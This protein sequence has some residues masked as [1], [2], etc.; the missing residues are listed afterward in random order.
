MRARKLGASCGSPARVD[1]RK[2][3]GESRAGTGDGVKHSRTDL[4]P[5]DLVRGGG[6]FT[7][8]NE[9]ILTVFRHACPGHVF[10]LLRYRK[11]FDIFALRCANLVEIHSH[12]GVR[13]R[14]APSLHIIRLDVVVSQRCRR[15]V[16]RVEKACP[17]ARRRG[18]QRGMQAHELAS[19]Q[20][21]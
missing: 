10:G 3:R 18:Q 14:L 17:G 20:D 16:S 11:D 2:Q 21:M 8:G 7:D 13:F 5:V 19:A 9:Q 1:T 6:A 4:R 12:V 15:G